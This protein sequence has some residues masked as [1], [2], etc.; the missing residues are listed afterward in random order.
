MTTKNG[1]LQSQIKGQNPYDV[2]IPVKVGSVGALVSIP[3]NQYLTE[4]GELFE[5]HTLEPDL[6]ID[7][8][9]EFI[10]ATGTTKDVHFIYKFE[11]SS[12]GL[13]EVYEG[14]STTTDGTAVIIYN[15]NRNSL[16]TSTNITITEDPT[17]VVGGVVIASNVVGIAGQTANQSEGGAVGP[18]IPLILKYGTKYHFIFTATFADTDISAVSFFYETDKTL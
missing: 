18:A 12:A 6:A 8:T 17:V 11:A 1:D 13:L 3:L 7:G 4:R 15:T 10:V 9:K 14:V 2:S 5:T 16:N